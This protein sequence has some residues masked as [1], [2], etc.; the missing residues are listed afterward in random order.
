LKISKILEAMM[1]VENVELNSGDDR[2]RVAYEMAREIWIGGDRSIDLENR[3]E[4]L[5]LVAE[6]VK[7]LNTFGGRSTKTK[8]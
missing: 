1:A 7:T 2:A 4:F 8:G 6:C 5:D 3:A